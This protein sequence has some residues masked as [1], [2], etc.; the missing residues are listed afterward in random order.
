[1]ANGLRNY[2]DNAYQ[3]LKRN[4]YGNEYECAGLYAIYIDEI[5]V[6][7]GKSDNILRRLAQHYVG[8]K[9][10]S[11]RKYRILAEAKRKGH[12]VCLRKIYQAKSKRK[13]EIEEEIGKK[14]GEYIRRYLPP[15]NYQI[16]KAENWRQFTTNPAAIRKTLKG[17]INGG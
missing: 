16:P 14:E 17:I 7:I 11:E 2:V 3:W 12:K 15:L 4:G 13:W 8:I 5:L 1:M 9:T 10:N 6:Y